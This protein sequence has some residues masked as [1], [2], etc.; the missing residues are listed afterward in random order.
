[1]FLDIF[2]N[3]FAMQNILVVQSW[4]SGLFVARMRP[5]AV[6]TTSSFGHSGA[7]QRVARDLGDSEMHESAA[8]RIESCCC[9]RRGTKLDIKRY[10]AGHQVVQSWTFNGTKLDNQF[11]NLL[12]NIRKNGFVGRR[13]VL[14]TVF[15]DFS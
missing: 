9:P 11:C 6:C 5:F 7:L 13:T 4:T 15:E 10:K 1:L 14:K 8:S 3:D 2:W 12:I